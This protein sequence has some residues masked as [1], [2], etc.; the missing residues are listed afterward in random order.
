MGFEAVERQWTRDKL[1]DVAKAVKAFPSD[2]SYVLDEVTVLDL[3][4]MAQVAEYDV[5]LRLT[6]R[7]IVPD[8][9]PEEWSA[10]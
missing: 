4:K 5:V 3:M 6:P 1:D 10:N 7:N 8:T 9:F 2:Q